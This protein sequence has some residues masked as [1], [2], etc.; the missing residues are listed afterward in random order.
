[1]TENF[2]EQSHVAASALFAPS[3]RCSRWLVI[4]TIALLIDLALG[5]ASTALEFQ[6]WGEEGFTPDV[7]L[8]YLAVLPQI[9]I[10]V[11]YLV[12][13]REAEMRGLWKSAAG[14][15]GSYLL[16]CLFGLVMMEVL[17]KTG[18]IAIMIAVAVGL[19]GLIGFLIS[20][21]PGFAQHCEPVADAQSTA[22]ES[23]SSGGPGWIGAFAMFIGF[24]VLRGLFRVFIKPML[25]AGFDIDDWQM[26]ELL[27]LVVFGVSFAMWFAV[28]KILHRRT[29]GGMACVTGTV[30]ILILLIHAGMAITIIT[31]LINEVA[32]NPLLDDAAVDQL[33]DPWAKRASLAFAASHAVWVVLTV[34]FFVSVRNRSKSHWAAD[35]DTYDQDS[36]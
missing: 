20:G 11:S 25:G 29:L 34:M 12:F 6:H 2:G 30:E 26:V 28:T 5:V 24:L 9:L 27:A 19:L 21:I 10:V 14:M 18:N 35:A 17:P 3:E 4:G 33:L 23:Q 13:A 1:M 36:K 16:V 15:L 31:I 32:V 22:D 8:T 7:V